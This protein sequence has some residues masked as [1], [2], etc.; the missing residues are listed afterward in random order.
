MKCDKTLEKF[1]HIAFESF[2]PVP[3]HNR[4]FYD[5]RVYLSSGFIWYSLEVLIGHFY[6]ESLYGLVEY[7]ADSVMV[8]VD[9]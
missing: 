3:F 1:L 6:K 2:S 9:K 8:G 4:T 5:I 7:L